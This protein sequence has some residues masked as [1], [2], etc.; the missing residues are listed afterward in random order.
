MTSAEFVDKLRL[1]AP[2]EKSLI[3]RGFDKDFILVYING[4]F[5]KK[6]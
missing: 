1:I 6:K 3:E 2:S 4:F 5:G